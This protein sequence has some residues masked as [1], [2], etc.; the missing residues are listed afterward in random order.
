MNRAT[1]RSSL[2]VSTLCT[3]AL[4][5]A[6]ALADFDKS[7]DLAGDE[8]VL[9]NLIG[10]ITVEGHG[11][12]KFR[13]EVQ[14]RGDD[15]SPSNLEIEMREGGTA[16]LAVRFPLDREKDYVYPRMGRGSRSSFDLDRGDREGL[17]GIVSRIFG[18]G[19]RIKVSG[20]G[21]GMELWADVT[22][23]VPSGARA[24]IRHGV[25]EIRASNV[26]GGLVLDI[27]S[28]AIEARNIRGDLVVDTGSGK[29]IVEDVQG[30]SIT[31]D[32][33]SGHVEATRVE[34]DKINFDTG[35]GRIQFD[36]VSGDS[37]RMDTGSGGISG[38]GLSA[39]EGKLDTGSGSIDV[40]FDRVGE[41]RFVMDTGSG[42]I[43][44]RLPPDASATIHA[45]TGS[46]GVSVD[47]PGADIRHMDRDEADIVIGGGT[48][49]FQLD[50][51]SGSIRISG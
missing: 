10:E 6:P 21:S 14:V 45:E 46:G 51:G 2:L 15:A 48:A 37:V 18:G 3:L 38:S 23:K 41:G 25:G 39:N 5:F 42:S 24:E 31:V 4:A 50:T 20:S 7:F 8:L 30:S 12:D 29:A 17:S 28:G 36:T 19:G 13:V 34:G 49:E 47:V 40:E 26:E 16:E 9:T 43:K 33:G 35:S 44:L 27:R 22:V 32:T 11:G 1:R